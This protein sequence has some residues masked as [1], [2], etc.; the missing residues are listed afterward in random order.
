MTIRTSVRAALVGIV[1]M[2]SSIGTTA[3]FAG[4][5]DPGTGGGPTAPTDAQRVL[6]RALR[7]IGSAVHEACDDL[8]RIG[9]TTVGRIGRLDRQGAD[10]AQITEVGAGA[11]ERV[12]ERSANAVARIGTMK[13]NALAA[14]ET[15]GGSAEQA[16]RLNDAADAAVAR[17]NECRDHVV[18]RINAAVARANG[19]G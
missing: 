13:T 14:L 10:A 11:V 3:A 7:G 18:G 2:A 9:Q 17:V 19:G 4:P 16:L 5:T 8:R 12:N 6:G 15:A 1:V